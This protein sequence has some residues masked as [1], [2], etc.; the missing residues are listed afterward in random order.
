MTFRIAATMLALALPLCA[1]EPAASDVEAVFYKAFYLE[2]GK[3]DIAGA[4]VLYDQFL[5]KAPA[6]HPLATEAARQ[7]FGLLDRT[8]KT[9]ARDAFRAKYAKLLG[10]MANAP[11]R[12]A[13][14]GDGG[15]A[16]G[17]GRRGARGQGGPG[18]G[19][20][21]AARIAELEKELAKAKE[22]GDT[23][24][25][26]R[27]QQQIDRMKRFAER[28]GPGGQ[29]GFGGRGLM[30]VLRGD[31]KIADMNAEQLQQLKDGLEQSGAMID[32]MR[33][34]GN[35]EAA[36]KMDASVGKLKKALAD[37]KL[38]EAQKA[39]DELKQAMP[40][41]GRR[42]GGAGGGAGGGRG[43]GNGGNS[44]GGGGGGN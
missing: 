40:Q 3:G 39:L 27:L 6:E 17:A 34:M 23:A 7:Q 26:E 43:G 15:D 10:N 1:Q 28:G 44:G 37:N 30:G 16:A 29:G 9:E 42:G 33:E 13:P 14:A 21:P 2:K 8:G 5:A 11:A 18:G 31:T 4:M 36:D 12:P 32:R 41:R 24:A 20:D 38:D 19:M 25:Q 22:E 35:A